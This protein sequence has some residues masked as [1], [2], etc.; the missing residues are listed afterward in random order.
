MEIFVT[1]DDGW[2]AKGILTIVR[3]MSELGHV[4]V[5]APDGARS[6]MSNAITVAQPIYL[7]PLNDPNWGLEEWQKH[8]TVYT[9]NGTPSDCVK[10]AI[11]VVCDAGDAAHLRV[12]SVAT[13][14]GYHIAGIEGWVANGGRVE[15]Y[16][17]DLRHTVQNIGQQF[18]SGGFQTEL[19]Q[20]IDAQVHGQAIINRQSVIFRNFRHH[21]CGGHRCVP[22]H[23]VGVAT[24][25]A[26]CGRNGGYRSVTII[27]QFQLALTVDLAETSQHLR[28]VVQ[29]ISPCFDIVI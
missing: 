1:N 22:G 6:G 23:E 13:R 10:L 19:Q 29:Q 21:I 4:T 3:I 15:R 12:I 17:V 8:V 11:D 2:G 5:V 18:F 16:I 20:R 25:K 9:T 28:G 26:V 27:Y 24:G 14:A 7:R